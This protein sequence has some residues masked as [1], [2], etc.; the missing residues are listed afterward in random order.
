MR[1]IRNHQ[2]T[3]NNHALMFAAGVEQVISDK[4]SHPSQYCDQEFR[5]LQNIAIKQAPKETPFRILFR[6]ITY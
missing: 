3:S 2:A 5:N 1:R 6:Q 4:L